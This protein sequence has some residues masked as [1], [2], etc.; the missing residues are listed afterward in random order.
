MNAQENSP[1]ALHQL[2]LIDTIDTFFSDYGLKTMTQTISD[3]LNDQL[4]NKGLDL[5]KEYIQETVCHV[6][7]LITFLS[8]I[9]ETRYKLRLLE[10]DNS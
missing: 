2:N 5:N 8:A 10:R 1:Y 3:L 9:S 4:Q 7:E 6:T